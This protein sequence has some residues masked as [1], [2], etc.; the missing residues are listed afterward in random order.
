MSDALNAAPT[1]CR[2]FRVRGRVQGVFF[3]ASTQERAE[4]LGLTGYAIN[5]EN[6]EVEVL[7]CG[8]ESLVD[9]LERWL[10]DGPP[11]AQVT[12]VRAEQS[13]APA[14]DTFSTA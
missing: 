9:E 10:W 5:L 11:T 8:P 3:R 13:P 6:G 4:Q 2:L 7:A 1:T 12:N 14:P